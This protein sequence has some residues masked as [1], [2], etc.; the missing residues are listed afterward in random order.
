MNWREIYT[1]KLKP[2]KEAVKVVKS[3]DKVVIGHAVGEPIKLVDAMTEYAVQADLRD[4]EIYQQV[5]MGH[6]FM[7]SL[8]WRNISGEQFVSWSKDQRLCEQRPGDFTPCYFY[9]APEFYRSTK[10]PDVVFVTLSLPDEHGYC[11][12]GVSCDYTKP[13]AEVEGAKVVAAVN[14]NMP[15]TLGDSFIHVSDIDVIVEDDTPIPELGLPQIGMWKWQ[16]E[17]T[18]LLW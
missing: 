16:S 9:Q 15:R 8:G 14:P 11:S 12:F 1:S 18:L 5:D 4:I 10:K 3:G 13:A 2:I 7:H 6:S 17:S